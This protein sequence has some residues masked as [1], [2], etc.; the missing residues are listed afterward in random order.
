MLSLLITDYIWSSK[1]LGTFCV[2]SS[3]QSAR[4]VCCPLFLRSKT[5]WIR[6]TSWGEIQARTTPRRLAREAGKLGDR[7]RR[8]S[9]ARAC[10]LSSHP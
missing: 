5:M 2:F 3:H 4:Q 1:D 10:S 6:T 9:L 8:H 7:E